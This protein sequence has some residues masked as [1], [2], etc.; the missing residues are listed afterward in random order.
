MNSRMQHPP[1]KI[2]PSYTQYRREL[3]R[4]SW[5]I[6]NFLSIVGYLSA[7]Q[8]LYRRRITKKGLSPRDFRPNYATEL[9]RELAERVDERNKDK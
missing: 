2:H 3:L 6:V 8:S 7:T 1:S 5:L 4:H 9:A